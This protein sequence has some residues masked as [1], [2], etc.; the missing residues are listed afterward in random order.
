MQLL[1]VA[2]EAGF[3]EGLGEQ[4]DRHLF[5]GEVLQH[6]VAFGNLFLHKDFTNDHVFGTLEV[7]ML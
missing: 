2:V 1:Q 6:R 4:V 7:R 3:R 5:G